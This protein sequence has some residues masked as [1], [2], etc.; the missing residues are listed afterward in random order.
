MTLKSYDTPLPDAGADST[1]GTGLKGHKL[2]MLVPPPFAP[3]AEYLAQLKEKYPDLEVFVHSTTWADKTTPTPSEES[4]WRWED[5]T[6]LVTGSALPD[7]EKAVKLQYVQLLSAGANH[8][9]KNPLF[10]ETDVAFCTANGVHGPQISE[11]IV[12]TLLSFEHHFPK[13][14]DEQKK[15]SWE[16]TAEYQNVT[17]SV[18]R[19]IGILGY[20]SIG[21]QTAKVCKAMGM[22]V[23]AYTLHPRE[24]AKSR[25]DASYA[26]PGTGDPEGIF[27]SRWFS[28]GSK[29]DLHSFL[30][31]DLDVLVISTPLTDKTTHL[32]GAE[33]LEIL[34]RRRT[35]ISNIARGPI[36]DTDALVHALET[37]GIR[38]AALDVTDPEPLPKD[39]ALWRTKNVII[40]PHISAASLAYG[41]RVLDIL[42][43]NLNKL[44]K[45]GDLINH[46]SRERGY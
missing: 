11:W 17:D 32:I 4:G 14:W 26:P 28:G 44:S 15:C 16:H 19:R 40:T 2:L 5:I 23:H 46:V 33:E 6:I 29:E 31:S 43:L 20:G 13:L 27:P 12:G 3:S 10:A 7:K 37:G 38:G 35:F 1:L 8:I 21:R 36:L 41:K 45:G 42:G 24:T 9:L 22:D 34:S 30:A 39:H 25:R 18:A